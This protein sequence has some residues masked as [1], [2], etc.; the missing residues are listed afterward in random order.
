[1]QAPIN[2]QSS[3][4]SLSITELVENRA[5]K[6]ADKWEHYLPVYQDILLPFREDPISLLE[7]GVQNGGSLEIWGS[8]L[9]GAEAIIG[10]DIDASCGE[11]KYDDP[12][13]QIVVGDSADPATAADIFRRSPS[14][15]VI[16]DDGSHL[17]GDII[18]AFCVYFP[19]LKDNGVYVV[20]D[21]HCSYWQEFEGGLFHPFSSMAFFKHLGDCVNHQHWGVDK[22]IKSIVTGI[23]SHYSCDIDELDLT[24]VYSVE[25]T[26]S[27]CVIRK[28]KPKENQIGRRIISGSEASVRPVDMHLTEAPITFEQSSNAWTI[29]HHPPAEELI[30][31]LA[32]I[33]H[34][35]EIATNEAVE[36]DRLQSQLAEQK[37][38]VEVSATALDA[39]HKTSRA[40]IGQLEET[41]ATET[42]KRMRLQ[43]RLA[44]EQQ[45]LTA[46]A[47]ALG[48]LK[49][50]RSWRLTAPLRAVARTVRKVGL[51]IP[52]VR[53]TLHVSRAGL[54]AFRRGGWRSVDNIL[55]NVDT[56]PEYRAIVQQTFG[57]RA[58]IIWPI[59]IL[60]RLY[61]S[62]KR[63]IGRIVRINH[64]NTSRTLATQGLYFHVDE[65]VWRL[66]V[67]RGPHIRVSGWAFDAST[68][69]S[70][71]VRIAAAGKPANVVA[72]TRPDV[73][74]AFAWVLRSNIACGFVAEVG[75]GLGL[76]RVVVELQQED[77]RWMRVSRSLALRVPGESPPADVSVN[78]MDSH[79]ALTRHERAESN[80]FRRDALA[81]L[82]RPT[83]SVVVDAREGEQGLED[84]LKSLASQIYQASDIQ[85]WST[86]KVANALP[87]GVARVASLGLA[88]LP[89]EFF[90][91]MRPG[92]EL[93]ESAL[94]HFASALNHTPNLDLIYCDEQ[95]PPN[96]STQDPLIFNKPDWSPDYLEATDYIGRAACYRKAR[97]AS[98]LETLTTGYDL[99]LRLTE[100]NV[101]VKHIPKVLIK[102]D[103]AIPPSN[104][105]A[106]K[107]AD[108]EA[109]AGRLARTGRIGTVRP[110]PQ[111]DG[112][113]LSEL[114]WD[115]F[116]LVSIVIPTAG[117]TV[118]VGTRDIDLIVHVIEQIRNQSSYPNIEILVVDNGD[119]T[120]SQITALDAAECIRITYSN[121]VF[122]IAEKLNLGSSKASGEFLLLLNDDIEIIDPDWI[123]RMLDQLVKPG[124]GVVGARLLYP[125]GLTQHVG[126]VHNYSNPDHVRRG[127][128]GDEAGYFFS[129]CGVRN[130]LAV[131]GA[132]MMTRTD[133]F[134]LVGGYTERLAVSFND[135]D[136][137]LKIRELGFRTVYAPQALL[138]HMESMSRE[139]FADP[140][141]L[142]Y[143]HRR[144]AKVLTRDSYYNERFLSV[145]PPTF[146]P[147]FKRR[148]L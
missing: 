18:K 69:K 92:D 6:V 143:Y 88:D 81:M 32:E 71:P 93:A 97:A 96:R 49:K 107:V 63:L 79:Q 17:S 5:G 133:L 130:Y 118:R 41:V 103:G 108:T 62:S 34:L 121:P 56:S 94:Y 144:W 89:G 124:V 135:V 30:D 9:P 140:D 47:S 91:L 95:R 65:P 7:I 85:V 51:A 2:S 23:L 45:K 123:E 57:S 122:N 29:R 109:L 80:E 68:E 55:I 40:E 77:G 13:I 74:R 125:N 72:K 22:S 105:A 27:M 10:N 35:K 98:V 131:T 59:R 36:R 61:S 104:A 87:A 19:H 102:T 64:S 142:E 15:D 145:N 50:S 112:C 111:Y 138:T 58:T 39:L 115:R 113:Y 75:V 42:A 117:R 101:E 120:Q 52:L 53:P 25:F 3:S 73:V 134:Q 8:F 114:Q 84:T 46:T 14:F 86:N 129:T 141:E 139:A 11:L 136:Y 82:Y 21:L 43:L 147:S 127:Y 20:E 44:D 148:M 33:G 16:I 128:A 28:R 132:C 126:V 60:A 100:G 48:A 4:G 90:V 37:L 66:S 12:R 76:S 116:P 99:N 119:L 146:Q 26:N 1:L 67:L 137:C 106:A 78:E 110:H 38:K 70:L 54:T 83:F 31:R 24:Q